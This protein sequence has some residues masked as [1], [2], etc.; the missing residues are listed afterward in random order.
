MKVEIFK[1]LDHLYCKPENPIYSEI[2]KNGMLIGWEMVN[3][4]TV[5]KKHN[6]VLAIPDPNRNWAMLVFGKYPVQKFLLKSV[7]CVTISRLEDHPNLIK[8]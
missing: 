6:F 5:C 1:A 8:E 4:I 7:G 3:I 2:F